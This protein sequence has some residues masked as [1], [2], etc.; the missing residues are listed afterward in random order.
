ML[1]HRRMN[2]VASAIQCVCVYVCVCVCV[3]VL[4]TQSCPALCD[5]M[6]CSPPGSSVHGTLQARILEW[7]TISFSR[8][9]SRPRDRTLVSCTAGIFF[10]AWVTREAI[11]Y[12]IA[13]IC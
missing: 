7:I 11:V 10:T 3:C 5:L 12:I 4:V 2:T 9:S 1:Y 6:D 8:G 13:C